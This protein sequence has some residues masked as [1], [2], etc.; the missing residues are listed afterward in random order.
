MCQ[1]SYGDIAPNNPYTTI[2][3]LAGMCFGFMTY[4]YI[5]NNIIKAVIWT[6]QHRD[7]FRVELVTFDNYMQKLQLPMQYQY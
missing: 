6:N 5:V 2:Y 4:S 1:I 7:T 3:T